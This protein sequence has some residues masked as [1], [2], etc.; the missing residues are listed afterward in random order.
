MFVSSMALLNMP[1]PLSK[2]N[3]PNSLQKLKMPHFKPDIWLVSWS[4]IGVDLLSNLSQNKNTVTEYS[5]IYE[6]TYSGSNEHLIDKIKDFAEFT[7][8]LHYEIWTFPMEQDILPYDLV[9]SFNEDFKK[10]KRMVR[11]IGLKIPY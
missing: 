4:D 2:L 3:M 1:A 5:G 7:P 6:T 9:R 11:K 10:L 8:N